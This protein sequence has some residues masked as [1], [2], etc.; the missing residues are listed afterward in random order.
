MASVAGIVA[1]GVS[2]IDL[3]NSALLVKQL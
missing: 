1:D 3:P 2:Q